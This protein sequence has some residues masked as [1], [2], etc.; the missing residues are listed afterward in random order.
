MPVGQ[1]LAS[2]DLSEGAAVAELGP[3]NAA[4]RL[5]GWRRTGAEATSEA[6][7]DLDYPI[8]HRLPLG[9]IGSDEKLHDDPIRA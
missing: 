2:K 3:N 8:S 5:G 9:K 7:S 1:S 4:N 6:A